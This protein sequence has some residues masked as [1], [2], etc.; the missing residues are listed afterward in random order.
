M[1]RRFCSRIQWLKEGLLLVSIIPH[2]VPRRP[3]T[4]TLADKSVSIWKVG[5]HSDKDTENGD[6]CQF[7]CFRPEATR[8]TSALISLA[9]TSHVATCFFKA[10][11]GDPPRCPEVRKD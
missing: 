3:H 6:V 2:S 4:M 8:V 7:K 9:T 1:L 5:G 10:G 11:K